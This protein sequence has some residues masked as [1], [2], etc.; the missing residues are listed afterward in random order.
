[1]QRYKNLGKRSRFVLNFYT[2][3]AKANA[4]HNFHE[5]PLTIA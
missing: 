2:L 3:L 4:G 5:K 1:M